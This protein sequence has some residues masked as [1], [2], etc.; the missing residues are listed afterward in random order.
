MVFGLAM[1]L[2]FFMIKEN[3]KMIK[4]NDVIEVL[5]PISSIVNLP[6]QSIDSVI[7]SDVNNR[8]DNVIF[9]VSIKFKDTLKDFTNGCVICSELPLQMSINCNYLIFENPREAFQKLLAHF[10]T[11]AVSF[12]IA[13]SAIVPENIK[14]S[15]KVSIGENVV[16]EENVSF[17][18]NV[19][20][21]H[22]TV[23]CKGTKI[24]NNVIIGHNNT[25]GGVGFGYEKDENG[26]FQL[27][28]H[29]GGVIIGN[30]VEIGNNT[31]IDK[32][33]LGNTIIGDGTKID[34]L[35]HIA[36]NI[37]IGKNCAIIANAMIGGS[38]KIADGVWVAPSATLRDGLNVS[39]NAVVGLGAV[40]TKSIGENEV[41]AGNPAKK[42]E[43]KQ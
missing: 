20:I 15:T 37:E 16:I 18:E 32:A 36:H 14:N 22:N 8:L 35:V 38:T 4:I 10:F 41:W 33:V 23:I 7:K 34:N 13:K 3:Y 25:I 30:N 27:I 28:Q 21:G 24:G 9:W 17:G 6:N 2:P 26:N 43:P 1:K 19:I 29:L 12:I 11:P 5:K 31:C 40:L 39:K 42:F